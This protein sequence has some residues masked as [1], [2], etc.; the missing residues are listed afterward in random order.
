MSQ[1][2]LDDIIEAS[3]LSQDELLAEFIVF[4]WLRDQLSSNQTSE[5]LGVPRSQLQQLRDAPT[6]WG[7]SN[8]FEQF[9][10]FTS[11]KQ[12]EIL[13]LMECLTLVIEPPI[14]DEQQRAR[15]IIN[16]GIT[17]AQQAPSQ[18][19]EEIWQRFDTICQRI[20]NNNHASQ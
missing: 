10:A 5:L 11:S 8:F 18:S 17:R 6:F 14:P 2:T 3:G 16:A 7:K 19:P 12:P 4:L 9:N 1:L 20:A 15:D 13:A